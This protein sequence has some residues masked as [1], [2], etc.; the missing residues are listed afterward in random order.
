MYKYNFLCS[1]FVFG[2]LL[3]SYSFT[4]YKNKKTNFIPKTI[5]IF[6]S[7][8]KKLKKIKYLLNLLR[9][10]NFCKDLVSEPANILNPITYAENCLPLKKLGIKVKVLDLKQLEK[11]GMG[12]L[13]PVSIVLSM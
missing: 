11:I 9:S 13:I 5:N 1:N 8:N 10:I 2:F 6:S 12:S 3:R 4:K 7:K